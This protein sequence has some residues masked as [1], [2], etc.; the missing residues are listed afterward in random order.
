MHPVN[1]RCPFSRHS[2]NEDHDFYK[3]Q[4]P[5]RLIFVSPEAK[6]TQ[7]LIQNN[8]LSTLNATS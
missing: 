6:Q 7:A 4:E 5:F 1:V 8:V 2:P 3:I